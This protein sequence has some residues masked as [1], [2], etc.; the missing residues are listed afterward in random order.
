MRSLFQENVYGAKKNNRLRSFSSGRLCTYPHHQHVVV[1]VCIEQP[2]GWWRLG[3]EEAPVVMMIW[4][5]QSTNTEYYIVLSNCI[6]TQLHT[7]L[8]MC[9]RILIFS[10]TC[11]NIGTSKA[12]ETNFTLITADRR[13]RCVM[14][15]W[16]CYLIFT[17]G[18][19]WGPLIMD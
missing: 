3:R 6:S 2:G 14:Q 1:F 17:D 15:I 12:L 13:S 9:L 18:W 5:L 8:I 16:K 19:R 4:C 10:F 11:L 7:L